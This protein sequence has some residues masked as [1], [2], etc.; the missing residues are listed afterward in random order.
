LGALLAA[1]GAAGFIVVLLASEAMRLRWFS[2]NLGR[3]VLSVV[4][5][6][7]IVVAAVV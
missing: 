5:F 6:A 3:S 7:L 1:L 4:S 2:G